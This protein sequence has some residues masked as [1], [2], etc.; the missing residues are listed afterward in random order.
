MDTRL[1]EDHVRELRQ[2]VLGVLD[3]AAAHDGLRSLVIRLPESRLIDPV[4]LLEDTF[5]ETERLEHLHRAACDAVG[6]TELEATGLLLH[7][8]GRDV[9]EG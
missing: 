3:P 1:V 2:A 6:L 4:R 8:S 9:G 5:T 7:D